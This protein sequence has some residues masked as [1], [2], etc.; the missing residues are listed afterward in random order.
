MVLGGK[1]AGGGGVRKRK[2]L[3]RCRSEVL[4][5]VHCHSD[6]VGALGIAPMITVAGHGRPGVDGTAGIV[7]AEVAGCGVC[8]WEERV[9][10]V[11]AVDRGA[12]LGIAVGREVGV[13]S[14]GEDALLVVKGVILILL[15]VGVMRSPSNCPGVMVWTYG[16]WHAGLRRHGPTTVGRVPLLF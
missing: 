11:D 6:A 2:R 16:L 10:R 13:I 15:V 9:H 3:N 14:A 4:Q 5:H 8:A 7:C 12:C 1:G